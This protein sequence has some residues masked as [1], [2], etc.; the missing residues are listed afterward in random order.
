LLQTQSLVTLGE[1][2]HFF[3]DRD[4]R[5]LRLAGT[6]EDAERPILNGKVR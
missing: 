6:G 1:V 5:T 2:E 3:A 4:A